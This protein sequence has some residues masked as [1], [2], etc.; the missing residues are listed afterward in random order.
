MFVEF[1]IMIM[2]CEC[3]GYCSEG[4]FVQI[5]EVFLCMFIFLCEVECW[6]IFFACVVILPVCTLF[7][8]LCLLS[9]C[10]W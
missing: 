8:S 10:T 6:G 2:S 1:I 4:V 9:L 3:F 5:D 7:F